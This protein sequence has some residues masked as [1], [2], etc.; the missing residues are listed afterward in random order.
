MAM[1]KA[2]VMA[3]AYQN[4]LNLKEAKMQVKSKGEGRREKGEGRREEKYTILAV[5]HW[6]DSSLYEYSH[7]MQRNFDIGDYGKF[8]LEYSA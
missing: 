1:V 2:M 5:L 4:V 7:S 3:A 8:V 6:K